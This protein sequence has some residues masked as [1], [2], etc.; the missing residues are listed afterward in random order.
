M[1]ELGD[2]AGAVAVPPRDWQLHADGGA[3]VGVVDG[4]DQ[5][6]QPQQHRR[7]AQQR[8]RRLREQRG[9]GQASGQGQVQ[10]QT[11]S[12][13][14]FDQLPMLPDSEC[15]WL[16][17][18]G[19]PQVPNGFVRGPHDRVDRVVGTAAGAHCFQAMLLQAGHK[20]TRLAAVPA[21][22]RPEQRHALA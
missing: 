10:G 11:A 6:A 3:H 20:A 21:S 17:T 19:G 5:L 7:Q 12:S 18:K 2:D 4:V 16:L 9:L 14:A 8:Q 15:V 13:T 22:R 1:H